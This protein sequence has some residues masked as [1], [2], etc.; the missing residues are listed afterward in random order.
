[1][2]DLIDIL[3]NQLPKQKSET[4][5]YKV[6]CFDTPA[7]PKHVERTVC[8]DAVYFGCKNSRLDKLNLT[9]NTVH[10]TLRLT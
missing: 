3:S 4:D 7:V 6:T 1:L 5:Q 8:D 2:L 9:T 10:T